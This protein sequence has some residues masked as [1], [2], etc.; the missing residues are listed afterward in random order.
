[1]NHLPLELFWNCTEDH[2]IREIL[3]GHPVV[4]ILGLLMMKD[5]H[6]FTSLHCQYFDSRYHDT[7]PSTKALADLAAVLLLSP[8]SCSCWALRRFEKT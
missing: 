7:H 5:A 2:R 4:D 8:S 3:F 6:I 1:M